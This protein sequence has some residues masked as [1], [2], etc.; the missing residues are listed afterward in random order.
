MGNVWSGKKVSMNP[1]PTQGLSLFRPKNLSQKLLRVIF[2]IY[3]VVTCLVT[4]LQFLTEYLKT[5]GSILD[6]LKQLEET[7]RGPISTSLWQYNQNQLQALTSGLIAMPIIEGVD[8]LDKHG[9]AT[10]SK[11]SFASTAAPL[12]MFEIKSDMNWDLNGQ[13]TELGSLI[14]YS[15]SKVVL[16]RV[17]FGFF[18]IAITATL[19]I[20]VLFYLFVWAVDRF[21]S[22]PLKQ[23]MSQVDD[24]KL[25]QTTIRRINISTEESNELTQLQEHINRMLATM[26]RD[27][28]RLLEAEQAKRSWLEEAVA[29]RTEELLIVNR[30]LMDLAS[31]DSLTG[32]LNRRSFYEYAQHLID[33]S[34]RQKTS[35]CLVLM[36]L[37]HFK[38]INDTYG[39]FIG[40]RVL[41]H[42]VDTI[43]PLLRTSDLFG[44]IGG[45][46][47]AIFLPDT[48]LDGSFQLAERLRKLVGNSTFDV[49]GKTI[50]YTVSLGIAMCEPGDRSVDE[51]FKRA[52]LKLY[53]AKDMGRDRVRS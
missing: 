27:R 39:H 11:R 7:F 9:A 41:V 23:L 31:E 14:L 28:E 29:E 4:G 18:L 13:R 30:R 12:S 15:S 17:L 43:K 51:L 26:E 19:K 42:F 44:R 34:H 32:V 36:D 46:E 38:S 1:G 45:E 37:D 3:L 24:I 53:E 16:D 33:L 2:S 21:L 20:S 10:I 49:D 47:F 8:I 52:D 25:N 35:F 5:Q 50:A 22:T 40:D 48:D 6:E